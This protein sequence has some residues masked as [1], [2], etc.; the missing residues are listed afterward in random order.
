MKLSVVVICYNMARELPRTLRSLSTAMQRGI[1]A[2]DYE[3]IVV[4]N[5]STKPFD[6]DEC[7]RWLPNGSIHYLRDAGVS[8]VPAVNYG[9]QLARSDLVGVFIDGARIAS[10]GL[11]ATALAAARVHDRAVV[12]T[13]AFHLGP[14]VQM[15]SVPKGYNQVVEDALL[16]SSGWEN[17]GYRL[18]DISA[19]AGSSKKG[20][21]VLPHETNALFLTAAHWREIG[22][23]DSG[24]VTPGG[25]LANLDVWKRLCSEPRNQVVMLLGEATFHQVHGGIATNSPT[26]PLDEFHE[27]YRRLRGERFTPPNRRPMFFGSAAG[28]ALRW[29]E[30][31]AAIAR[32]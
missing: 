22:G 21:F 8:P 6:K 19:L 25:G 9:L 12:G 20:C 18:F 11:L 23:Y 3:V 5:G 31:S 16:A 14:E 17:D 1:A 29:I 2:E 13:I 27:E 15:Q 10:P 30:A 28:P 24:F 7:R 26:P 4:D 32:R